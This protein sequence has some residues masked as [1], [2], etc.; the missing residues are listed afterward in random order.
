MFLNLCIVGAVALLVGHAYAGG[1]NSATDDPALAW[2]AMNA[3]AGPMPRTMSNKG[4]ADAHPSAAGIGVPPGTYDIGGS[5]AAKR[6]WWRFPAQASPSRCR[7]GTQSMDMTSP[8]MCILTQVTKSP[9]PQHTV[10]TKSLPARWDWGRAIVDGNNGNA[11]NY[12]TRVRNQFLPSWCGS[13]W[14]HAA[15]AVMGARWKIHNPNVEVI[16]LSIPH[17]SPLMCVL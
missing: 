4:V 1:D 12:L 2:E 6:P 7:V 15:A 5:G 13:C 9:L 17:G 10:P 16:R 8:L 3:G 11:N 14:A